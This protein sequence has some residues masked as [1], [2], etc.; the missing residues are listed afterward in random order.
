M[1]YYAMIKEVVSGEMPMKSFQEI[2][3]S[4]EK[5]QSFLQDNLPE[6][7]L[8]IAPVCWSNGDINRVFHRNKWKTA[9]ERYEVFCTLKLFLE[10]SGVEFVATQKYRMEYCA[11]LDVMPTYINGEKAEMLA[12]QIIKDTPSEKSAVKRAKVIREKIKEAFH[13]EGRKY[14][15][16]PQDTDWPFSETGRP[17]KY[18]SQKSDGDLVRFTFLDV[19]TG[20]EVIVEDYY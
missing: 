19:D 11:L 3:F 15:R 13:I 9:F 4:D 2:Y 17:L 20:N 1:D 8:S 16:W 7:M 5:L 10:C 14:P 12:E 6:K 18:I